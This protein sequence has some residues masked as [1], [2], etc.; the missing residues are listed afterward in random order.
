MSR[1][2]ALTPVFLSLVLAVFVSACSMTRIAYSNA[3][4]ILSWMID[5]YFDLNDTQ[6]D[7]VRER[8]ER[9]VQWHR[10]S[11]LPD[12]ERYLQSLLVMSERPFTAADAGRTYQ[13]G[14][15]LYY[16]LA[17]KLL[18]DMA[19]FL[20]K[21][22]AEQLAAVEKNLATANARLARD[23]LKGTPE[24]RLKRRTRKFIGY[25]E[26]YFGRLSVQQAAL[27][28]TRVLAMPE[29]GEE[30]MADRKRRQQETLKLVRNKGTREQTIAGLRLVIFEMDTL[31]S[32]EYVAQLK[33]R[34]AHI[35]EMIASLSETST[36]EQ[37]NKLQKKI[38]GFLADVAYLMVASQASLGQR[39]FQTSTPGIRVAYRRMALKRSTEATS[40]AR[41]P[42]SKAEWPAS[43]TTT[44]SASGHARCKSS[45]ETA[46]QTTS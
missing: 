19:D 2:S 6:K 22:D 17:E 44:Y 18:P 3:T 32:P 23:I 16:R 14:R 11:E 1:K 40:W 15:A 31:R 12:Y 33:Q 36:A 30:W 28:S 21:L 4:P 38:R 25:F 45:A 35:F 10:S 20:L 39:R 42:G 27:V 46:G 24:E 9:L 8:T 5:D 29:I 34:D 7:W 37:R 43:F 13:S 41:M 26:D